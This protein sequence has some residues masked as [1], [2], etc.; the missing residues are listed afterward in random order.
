MLPHPADVDIALAVKE[1]GIEL[2]FA[3]ENHP[4]RK[5][6]FEPHEVSRA[7]LRI[8]HED[9]IMPHSRGIA[10]PAVNEV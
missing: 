2:D 6:I 5:Q 8:I 7:I 10:A 3:A 9:V 1:V 4:L